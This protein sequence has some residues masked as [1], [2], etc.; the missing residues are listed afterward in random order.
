[1]K[2]SSSRK[3]GVNFFAFILVLNNAYVIVCIFLD[4]GVAPF[5]VVALLE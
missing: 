1:M 4:Q 3:R 5:G 2:I